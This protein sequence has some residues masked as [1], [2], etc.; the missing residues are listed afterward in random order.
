MFTNDITLVGDAASTR[1]YALTGVSDGKS[2][3][4]NPLRSAALPERMTISHA[5][6]KKGT[7]ITDRHLV[8]FDNAVSDPLTGEVLTIG[9]YCVLE[10]PRNVNATAAV[11]KDMVTQ[12]KNFLS[13]GF[14]QQ[15][16]N[17]EP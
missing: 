13:A 4:A 3:R 9:V 12:L 17:N 1:T 6:S 11:A 10:I 2:I 14:V 15:L 7:L 16:L 8:R 5:P